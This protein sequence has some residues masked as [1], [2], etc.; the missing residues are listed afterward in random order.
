MMVYFDG[1]EGR[2][3]IRRARVVRLSTLKE[4]QDIVSQICMEA[5]A[6]QAQELGMGYGS[7][8][9]DSYGDGHSLVSGVAG[10]HQ[11]FD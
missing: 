7:D 2:L 6:L 11:Q 10:D 9:R 4:R 1:V 5:L 3:K 8:E